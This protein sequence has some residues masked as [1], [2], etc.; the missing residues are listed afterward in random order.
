LKRQHWKDGY[1]E[2]LSG[3]PFF[4]HEINLFVRPLSE[5]ETRSALRRSALSGHH[6]DA[7]ATRDRLEK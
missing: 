6:P 1:K 5:R 7:P 3:A 4:S 2:T